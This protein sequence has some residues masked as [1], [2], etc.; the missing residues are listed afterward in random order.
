[1]I[2]LLN[3]ATSAL[4]FL[5]N[6]LIVRSTGDLQTLDHFYA[7]MQIA[8]TISGF[9]SASILYNVVPKLIGS[10]GLQRQMQG[11]ARHFY[12]VVIVAV[13]LGLICAGLGYDKPAM[14]ALVLILLGLAI[15]GAI[16]QSLKMLRRAVGFQMLPQLFVVIIIFALRLPLIIE[17]TLALFLA[18][19]TSRVVLARELRQLGQ[20]DFPKLDVA[21][22]AML[23]H[24]MFAGIGSFVFSVYPFL[25][26]YFS[27]QMAEGSLTLLVIAQRVLIASANILI[28]ARFLKA[29]HEF[30]ESSSFRDSLGL[31]YRNM[32]FNTAIFCV[33]VVMVWAGF[34]PILS[35]FNITDQAGPFRHTITEMLP[36]TFFM[37]Q[38][39]FLLRFIKASDHRM[40]F[41]VVTIGIWIATYIA[42]FYLFE[43]HYKTLAFCYSMAWAV[44]VLC[45]F[46]P[47]TIRKLHRRRASALQSI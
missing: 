27:R 14:A 46:V 13:V 25:D 18:Y 19:T 37:M 17:Y 11:F 2:N 5:A 24:G 9:L 35:V 4:G 26:V 31:I 33:I 22:L 21:F 7:L 16:R 36:G 8:L 39:V 44:T 12:W 6:I 29:P 43:G 32:L 40:H 1:M 30:S 23:R 10:A 41:D 38:A 34:T 20:T 15:D 28:Y 3:L 47:A 45:V 42:S